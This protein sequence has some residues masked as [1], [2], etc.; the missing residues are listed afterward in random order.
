MNRIRIFKNF[1]P[2]I[3]YR[4]VHLSSQV[5]SKQTPRDSSS[6]TPLDPKF[7]RSVE[8]TVSISQSA[9]LKYKQK[10]NPNFND[11]FRIQQ[12]TSWF[13]KIILNCTANGQKNTR[14]EIIKSSYVDREFFEKPKFY[15][16]ET[17]VRTYKP[18]NR[19]PTTSSDD[20]PKRIIYLHGGGYCLCTIDTYH[21]LLRALS[22]NLN[23]EVIAIDYQSSPQVPQ[24]HSINQAISV[25]QVILNRYENKSISIAGDSAGGH[26]TLNVVL[27]LIKSKDQDKSKSGSVKLPKS[28]ILIYPWLSLRKVSPSWFQ[29]ISLNCKYQN[30][31]AGFVMNCMKGGQ[32]SEKSSFDIEYTLENM[33]TYLAI[34]NRDKSEISKCDPKVVTKFEKF[35]N[36]PKISTDLRTDQ[37][38]SEINEN[39]INFLINISDLDAL[40]DEGTDFYNQLQRTRTGS[41]ESNGSKIIKHVSKGTTHG[42]F[43][44]FASQAR[45]GY[46]KA[47]SWTP[48][49]DREFDNVINAIKKVL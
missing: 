17:K 13:D 30:I 19:E 8:N 29:P 12:L 18:E 14:T 16:F 10:V 43:Q 49:H 34:I 36:Q 3:N 21:P 47:K 2:V 27:D 24:P 41:D 11:I 4:Y 7:L 28:A 42:W 48:E 1:S 33:N 26:A 35:I 15:N 39:N 32:F 25:C 45:H 23:A 9:V 22:N 20:I 40:Y 6:T 31:L 44:C 37:E 5:K 46:R 38:I